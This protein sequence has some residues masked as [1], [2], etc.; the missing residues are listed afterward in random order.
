[1]HLKWQNNLTLHRNF[2]KSIC[3]KIQYSAVLILFHLV[4]VF[5][6]LRAFAQ[7]PVIIEP[8]GK[9]Q[10]W[11]NQV[12]INIARG[13][14]NP[15]THAMLFWTN[16]IKYGD[17]GVPAGLFIGGTLGHDKVMRQNAGYIAT[18]TAITYGVTYLIKHFV[19]RPRPFIKDIEIIPVYRAGSTSF[20]SG[21]AATSISTATALSIAYPKW[22]VIAPAF[23]WAGTISYSRMYLGVHYPTDVAVGSLIGTG[24]AVGMSF[25]KH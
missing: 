20:P 25:M 16:T 15:K 3:Q 1:M 6:G 18:S 22:Y 13:R 10:A 14:S 12:M 24:T 23:L 9:I 5:C 4:L 8:P 19:R 11:E 7:S 17:I 2:L 21:H